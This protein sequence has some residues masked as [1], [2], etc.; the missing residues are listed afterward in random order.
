MLQRQIDALFMHAR[1]VTHQ[2]ADIVQRQQRVDTQMSSADSRMVEMQRDFKRHAEEIDAR[3]DRIEARVTALDAG[4]SKML[5]SLTAIS[6]VT[7]QTRDILTT[8]KGVTTAV[9]WIGG[10]AA[11][12]AAV[13]TLVQ[14]VRG[15]P[16]FG[17]GP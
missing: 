5:E 12:V 14:L 6:V 4:Q 8:G 3:S 13:W 17:V 7:N 16:G 15:V 9:K 10:L 11:A 2:I 1:T